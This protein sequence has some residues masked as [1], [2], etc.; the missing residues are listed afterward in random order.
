MTAFDWIEEP[1]ESVRAASVPCRIATDRYLCAVVARRISM[2]AGFDARAA[3]EIAIC[4]S[5]L[6]SNAVRHARGGVLEVSVVETPRRGIEL[7]C[8]DF[9]AGIPNVEAALEDGWSRGRKLQPDESRRE[10]LGSG[11]GTIRRLMSELAVE[12]G[13]G[14]TVVVA[15]RFFPASRSHG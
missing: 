15:R 8:R 14:G 4:A 7:R 11:L 10:G 6:A 9:G 1:G 2:K 13:E 12:P 3:A 5:E